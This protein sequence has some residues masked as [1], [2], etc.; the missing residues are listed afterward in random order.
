[1]DGETQR[2]TSSRRDSQDWIVPDIAA[3]VDLAIAAAGI[4]EDEID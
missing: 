2:E 4:A 1:M 3:T